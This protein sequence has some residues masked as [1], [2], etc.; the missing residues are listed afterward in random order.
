MSKKTAF[1][2]FIEQLPERMKN[3]LQKNIELTKRSEKE[4]IE[5][6]FNEGGKQYIA[7]IAG[8]TPPKSQDYYNK[9]YG[10]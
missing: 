9:T 7:N 3:Y 4:Q 1:E 10:K 6:A 8:D 2:F 5:D